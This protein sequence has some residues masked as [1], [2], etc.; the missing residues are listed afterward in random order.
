MS[1]RIIMQKAYMKIR[2]CKYFLHILLIIED[3]IFKINRPFQQ[4]VYIHDNDEFDKL[5]FHKLATV[6][7]KISVNKENET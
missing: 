6:I 4:L 7:L 1:R 5:F 2:L 3:F